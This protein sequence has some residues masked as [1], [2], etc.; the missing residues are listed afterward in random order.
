LTVEAA[1]SV[2]SHDSIAAIKKE[3]EARASEITRVATAAEFNGLK[4]LEGVGAAGD[5][6]TSGARFQVAA[7]YAETDKLADATTAVNAIYASADIFVSAK[8]DDLKIDQDAIDAAFIFADPF[9]PGVDAIDP[10]DDTGSDDAVTSADAAAAFIETV[11]AALK[12]INNRKAE[13]GALQNRLESAANSLVTT[14]E[15]QSAARST[16]MD[17]DIAEESSNYTKAQ[18]LQQTSAA[19]LVQANQMPSL[20]LKLIS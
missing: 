13:I 10:S 9:D 4:L 20:A 19:L 1:N 15:N 2:Y 6:G 7:N 8:A 17:A 11:D 14:I 16:I 5:L 3:V 18:I 12:D